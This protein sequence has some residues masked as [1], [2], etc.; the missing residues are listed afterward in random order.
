MTV[1]VAL[2][3]TWCNPLTVCVCLCV[4]VCIWAVF[5]S[6]DMGDGHAIVC[7]PLYPATGTTH[8]P[9]QAL[10]RAL[11]LFFG[12]YV[13]CR[14]VSCHAVVRD[15]VKRCADRYGGRCMCLRV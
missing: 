8:A 12:R 9:G 7:N 2:C 10:G 11:F 14:D 5:E 1:A 6:L 15:T 4:S 13:T 3:G